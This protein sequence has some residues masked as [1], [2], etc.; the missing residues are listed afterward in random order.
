MCEP[1]IAKP[2]IVTTFISNLLTDPYLIFVPIPMLWVS[3]LKLIKKVAA[4]AV[5]GAGI[6]VL[7]CATFKSVFLL[8]VSS[9]LFE[10]HV[11]LEG[12]NPTLSQYLIFCLFPPVSGS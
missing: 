12:S 10:S 11:H 7:V 8:V 9:P 6:F 2:T 1:A 4:T 5:L 3:R